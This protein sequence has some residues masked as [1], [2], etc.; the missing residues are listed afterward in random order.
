MTL[1][2]PLVGHEKVTKEK[3]CNTS[4]EHDLI[5]ALNWLESNATCLEVIWKD[6]SGSVMKIL[7]L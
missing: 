6:I 7:K 3:L 2:F 5:Y 1:T 4:S